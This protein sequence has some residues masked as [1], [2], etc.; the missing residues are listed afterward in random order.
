MFCN[1]VRKNL[2]RFKS[3]IRQLSGALAEEKLAD[4]SRMQSW[5]VHSYGEDM[6]LSSIRIPIVYDTNEVLIQVEAASVNPIDVYM[7]DGYARTVLNLL[8][9]NE[10]ELPMTLGRD[11]CG[12]VVCKG[13]SVNSKYKI[14]D[15]VYGFIPLH[16]QGSFAQYVLADDG[17]I[18][19][20]PKQ[21]SPGES[22]SIVY[23]AMT[24]WGALFITGG[25]QFGNSENKRVLI[26]GASGG[27]GTIALQLL[28]SQKVHVTGSCSTNAVP[29]VK[30]LGADDVLDYTQP[31]Y[32]KEISDRRFD[33]ILDCAKFGA[34][35]IP[36]NWKFKQFISLNSP[37]ML[38]TDQYGLA[39]GLLKSGGTLLGTNIPHLKDG[40]VIKW[41]FFIPSESGFKFVHELVKNREIKPMLHKEF[42]FGQLPDAFD[43]VK[44]VTY[45]VKL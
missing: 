35:N 31:D 27:V 43:E 6:L 37:L 10:M 14:G 4:Q 8:R 36:R 24:A 20:H 7:K 16:K 2:G 12:T 26:L 40:K 19:H 23:A 3:E 25:L 21:L 41:G 18:C 5:Q 17:H 38:N 1:F 22:A 34:D 29:L 11:F 42:D 32:L 13:L 15:R 44:K 28:K 9:R 39:G 33:I 30:S 45:E